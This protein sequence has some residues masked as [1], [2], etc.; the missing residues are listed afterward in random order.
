[1]VEILLY[2]VALNLLLIVGILAAR[3]RARKPHTILLGGTLLL[4]VWL[5]QTG[6]TTGPLAL[7][8]VWL[9]CVFLLLPVLFSWLLRWAGRYQLYRLA[10]FLSR[11][12]DLLLLRPPQNTAETYR[13]LAR[14][15]AGKGEE[16]LREFREKLSRAEGFEEKALLVRQ[17]L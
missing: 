1:M 11:A 9:F 8:P 15:Q 17:L 13:A 2:L 5:L 7:L 12:T 4:A 3:G 16:V 10:A 14:I 6:R